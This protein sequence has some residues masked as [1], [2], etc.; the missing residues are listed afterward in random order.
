MRPSPKCLAARAEEVRGLRA[1]EA[2][3]FYERPA[4]FSSPSSF[5]RSSSLLPLAPT[6]GRDRLRPA[7][8]LGAEVLHGRHDVHGARGAAVAAAGSGRDRLEGGWIPYAQRERPAR[9]LRGTALEDLNK[10]PVFAR[11]R[12]L[13]GL[14]AGLRGGSGWVPPSGSTAAGR[15]SSTRRSRRRSSTTRAAASACAS[16]G[17]SGTRT[18]DF[19][20][21]EDVVS[22][23]PGS[24]GN[25]QGC[26]QRSDGR[27]DA[28]RRRRR[29]RRAA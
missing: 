29:A 11:P 24:P 17:S 14:P 6:A 15:T 1:R 2:C 16:T 10:T 25:P 12:L 5:R 19:T 13:V 4:R 28:E 20:C 22:Q 21:P 18:G 7:G 3:G 8:G 26:N 23:A 27:R 9:R